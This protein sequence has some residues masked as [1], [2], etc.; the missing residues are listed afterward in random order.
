[1]IKDASTAK[2]DTYWASYL[3]CLVEILLVENAAKEL[4]G[5]YGT[6]VVRAAAWWG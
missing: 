3:E 1:M 6:H 4:H 5:P 2:R